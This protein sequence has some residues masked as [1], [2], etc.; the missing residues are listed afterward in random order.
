MKKYRT[1]DIVRI[2]WLDACGQESESSPSEARHL[3]PIEMHTVGQVV[4]HDREKIT[5]AGTSH[6]DGGDDF[7]QNTLSIP[8]MMLLSIHQQLDATSAAA[9]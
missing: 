1:G 5:I 4:V 8:T 3:K 7:Y 2:R 9:S 6:F